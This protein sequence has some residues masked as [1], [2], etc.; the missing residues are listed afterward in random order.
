MVGKIKAALDSRR[1]DATMISARSDARPPKA[2]LTKLWNERIFAEA[3][4]MVFVESPRPE[5]R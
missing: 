1:N 5:F 4:D 2:S 3:A